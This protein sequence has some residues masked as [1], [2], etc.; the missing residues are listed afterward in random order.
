MK[1]T[2]L[3]AA[4]ANLLDSFVEPIKV[5]GKDVK[6]GDYCFVVTRWKQINGWFKIQDIEPDN[7]QFFYIVC[8]ANAGTLRAENRT[9]RLSMEK[10][11]IYRI[12]RCSEQ[13]S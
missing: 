5:L 6:V 12:K 10:N 2:E 13:P 1:S 3:N 4:L 8:K 7:Y 9:L 11:E